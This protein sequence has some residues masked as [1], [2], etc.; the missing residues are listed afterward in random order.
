MQID[1]EIQKATL[2]GADPYD[3][4][5]QEMLARCKTF[6]IQ[7]NVILENE[8]AAWKQEFQAALKQID[9]AAKAQ[10]AVGK[11]GGVNIIINMATRSGNFQLI[12]VA[13][14][15]IRENLRHS[16]I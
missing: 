13:V 12:M 7:I 16:V 8:M 10:A 2:K 14:N 4:Q 1:W 5:V 6:L 15:I 3:D 9:D 11:L